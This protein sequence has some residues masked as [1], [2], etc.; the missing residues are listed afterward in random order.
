MSA[1]AGQYEKRYAYN[2]DK[3]DQTPTG[4]GGKKLGKKKKKKPKKKRKKK[5]VR[6][7][8]SIRSIN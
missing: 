6:E 4:K 8:K 3:Q 5:K 7:T 2:T 1:I